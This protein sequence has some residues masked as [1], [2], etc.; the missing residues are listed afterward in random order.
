M[1]ET[2][3]R[4]SG[5]H[6]SNME[7]SSTNDKYSEFD[8]FLEMHLEEPR[9]PRTHDFCILKWWKVHNA[10]Y[11]TLAKMARDV[12]ATPVTTIA[13][14]SWFSIGGRIINETRASMLPELV[15]VL[16]TG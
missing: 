15:E 14:E 13:S 5:S 6:N 8:K 7:T 9:F 2:V 1:G 11:P 12:L 4:N 16:I 3:D 10:K